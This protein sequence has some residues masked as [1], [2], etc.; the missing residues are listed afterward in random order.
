MEVRECREGIE[1]TFNEDEGMIFQCP[2]CSDVWMSENETIAAC[3]HIRFLYSTFTQGF[4][5][6]GDDW[7]HASF[8]N[9]FRV[10]AHFDDHDCHA[11][12][13]QAFRDIN[14]PDVDTVVYWDQEEG[15][16][17]SSIIYWG[18]KT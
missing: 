6:F 14:H 10:L 12:E 1:Y 17:V 4:L 5:F 8:E 13:E 9:P 16:G 3:Q 11:D 18:Y 15:M 2:V 7:D